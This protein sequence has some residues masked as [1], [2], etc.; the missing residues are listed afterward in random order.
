MYFVLLLTA[1]TCTCTY[2]HVSATHANVKPPALPSWIAFNNFSLIS[3]SDVY[4]GKSNWLKQVCDWGN[5]VAEMNN[6]EQQ[7]KQEKNN[8]NHQSPCHSQQSTGPIKPPPTRTLLPSP[9][10]TR[11]ARFHTHQ[12]NLKFLWP[13]HSLQCL[14]T[15][16]GHFRSTRDVLH[17]Q[18]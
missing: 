3:F 7:K 10:R 13:I 4:I 1:Y 15:T 14:K 16:D 11:R 8:G 5:G 9:R 2:I 12:M 17:K 18:C 6:Q